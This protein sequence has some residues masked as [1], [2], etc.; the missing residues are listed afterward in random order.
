MAKLIINSQGCYAAYKE[1]AA[2][3]V[4]QAVNDFRSSRKF[5]LKHIEDYSPERVSEILAYQEKRYALEKKKYIAKHGDAKG[6]KRVPLPE[7]R[8]AGMMQ[9]AYQEIE[10]IT[11]FFH[12]SWYKALTDIDPDRVL[13][14]LQSETYEKKPGT[15]NPDTK[16]KKQ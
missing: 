9:H 2:A 8:M 4:M 16:A 3:I 1:L 7:E 6:F 12:S 13:K 11:S 10:E 15:K 5:I 14:Q